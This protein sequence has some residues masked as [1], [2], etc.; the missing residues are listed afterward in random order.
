M[1]NTPLKAFAKIGNSALKQTNSYVNKNLEGD[2]MRTRATAK[3]NKEDKASGKIEYDGA[4]K[5]KGNSGAQPI[6]QD[7]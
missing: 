7:Y 4:K 2:Q 3:K 5:S 6:M 1:R